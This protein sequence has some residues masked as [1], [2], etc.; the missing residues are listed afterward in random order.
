MEPYE[1]MM[2]RL[3]DLAAQRK[4][5]HS[6]RDIETAD[7]YAE[8]LEDALQQ[9]NQAYQW[10]PIPYVCKKC[11]KGGTAE[12]PHMAFP[13][14][15]IKE[16]SGAAALCMAEDHAELHPECESFVIDYSKWGGK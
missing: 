9:S 14:G 3:N 16:I 13:L 15:V 11:G 2:A 7:A 6:P 12:V 5:R 8:A 10:R 1:R 4:A